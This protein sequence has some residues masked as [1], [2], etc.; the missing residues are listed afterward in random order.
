MER[1]SWYSKICDIIVWWDEERGDRKKM[2]K[3]AYCE[4]VFELDQKLIVGIP[5]FSR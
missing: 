5:L 4:H 3:E 2:K 1:H